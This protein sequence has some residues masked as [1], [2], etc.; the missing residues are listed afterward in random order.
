[1]PFFMRRRCYHQVDSFHK[2]HPLTA[3]G[4]NDISHYL[5]II[6]PET[7]RGNQMDAAMGTILVLVLFITVALGVDIILAIVFGKMAARKGYSAI[8]FGILVFFLGLVGMIVVAVLPDKARAEREEALVSALQSHAV[9]AAGSG[10]TSATRLTAVAKLP[11]PEYKLATPGRYERL[12]QNRAMYY[13]SGS[14]IIEM[15]SALLK[16]TQTGA[17]IAQTKFKNISDKPITAV[18]VDIDAEDVTGEQLQGIYNFQYLDITASRGKSFG[19]EIPVHLPDTRTRSFT[20]HTHKVLFADGSFWEPAAEAEWEPIPRKTLKRALG[21]QELVEQYRRETTTLAKLVPARFSDI[22]L[23]A[24]GEINHGDDRFCYNCGLGADQT[25]HTLHKAELKAQLAEFQKRERQQ[26]IKAIGFRIIATGAVF[27]ILF[28]PS[29]FSRSGI[30]IVFAVIAALWVFA[31][32][33][34]S[35]VYHLLGYPK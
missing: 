7:E 31:S 25:D 24:C 3:K 1:M 2:G 30:G 9:G 10:Q 20:L 22:W 15:A 35:K 27:T 32:L 6:M 4:K 21:E 28:L 14:P 23:C 18:V 12:S 34:K 29:F 16:D 13:T 5:D 26:H 8:G 17:I 33:S 19:G 11:D